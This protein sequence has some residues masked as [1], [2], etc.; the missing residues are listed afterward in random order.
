MKKP[1]KKALSLFLCLLLTAAI[2]VCVSATPA[3]EEYLLEKEKMSFIFPQNVVVLTPDTPINSSDWN[4]AGIQDPAEYYQRYDALSAAAHFAS[5]GGRYNVYLA[6]KTSMA[7]SSIFNLTAAN[8]EVKSAVMEDCERINLNE[9]FDSSPEFVEIGDYLF[10]ANRIHFQNETTTMDEMSYMTVMNGVSYTF[11]SHMYGALE[12]GDLDFIKMIVSSLRFTE[13]MDTPQKD[14]SASA[15]FR[16][17][18]PLLLA[19]AVLIALVV[20]LKVRSSRLK[21]RK[22]Q[23]ADGLSEFR[24]RRKALEEAGELQESETVFLNKTV[25]GDDALRRFAVF[26]SYRKNPLTIPIYLIAVILSVSIVVSLIKRASDHWF[27]MLLFSAIALYSLYRLLTTSKKITRELLRSYQ[28]YPNRV[29]IFSFRDD[30]FRL[31]GLQANGIYPYLQITEAYETKDF[32]YLYFG[33]DHA[34]LVNKAGFALG[35]PADFSR[36]LKEKVGRH[37]HRR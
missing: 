5:P 36:F 22:K 6:T 1:F 17:L 27:W 21:K 25:H 26:H 15:V 32:F 9:G 30:S 14:T 24:S 12:E 23:I 18:L 28:K 10:V 34:F 29:A 8:E 16:G 20:Y 11:S 3:G 35:D 4:A 37:F 2:T 33:E 7:V 19:V 31:S 13:I